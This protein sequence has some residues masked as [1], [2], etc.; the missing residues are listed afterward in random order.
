M[1]FST[2]TNQPFKNH[3]FY[4][5]EKKKTPSDQIQK[6]TKTLSSSLSSYFIL[7]SSY[8]KIMFKKIENWKRNEHKIKT[9]KSKISSCRISSILYFTYIQNYISFFLFLRIDSVN[10]ALGPLG[11]VHPHF[12]YNL[13]VFL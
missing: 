10:T 3:P 11:R 5:Q 8:D 9:R 12:C 1:W 13:Y 4:S 6:E 7:T 2:L